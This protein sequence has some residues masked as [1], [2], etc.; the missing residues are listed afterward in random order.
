MKRYRTPLKTLL[1]IAHYEKQ[2]AEKSLGDSMAYVNTINQRIAR[3]HATKAHIAVRSVGHNGA[4]QAINRYDLE[5]EH[6]YL[7][8]LRSLEKR[9][10]EELRTAYRTLLDRRSEYK[11]R[12]AMFSAYEQGYNRRFRHHRVIMERKNQYEYDEKGTHQWRAR[13]EERG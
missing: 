7:L 3:I 10:E 12:Y 4:S 2:K 9:E 13:M 1:R 8:H 5:I 11:K 6:R